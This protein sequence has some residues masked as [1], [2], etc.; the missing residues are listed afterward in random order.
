M[1]TETADLRY[2]FRQAIFTPKGDDP[3]RKRVFVYLPREVI[4]SLQ[5]GDGDCITFAVSPKLPYVVLINLRNN[6]SLPKNLGGDS[7]DPRLMVATLQ[8]E[9]FEL[10]ARR[11]VL[12][13][14][15]NTHAIDNQKYLEE[16]NRIRQR[17]DEIRNGLLKIYS[18]RLYR[19]SELDLDEIESTQILA[20]VRERAEGV[21]SEVASLLS[22]MER[23]S[24]KLEILNTLLDG[25]LI[26][27][28]AH[29]Q[30]R[31]L[32]KLKLQVAEDAL[33]GVS[34]LLKQR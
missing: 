19:G 31:E 32:T 22:D 20:F 12:E 16:K 21:V 23:Y 7:D 1:T 34:K 18:T 5:I 25:G 9:L 17:V 29:K 33:D 4:D 13:E 8:A 27:T 11:D 30:A 15:W 24:R 26:D 14:A 28:S 10:D 2:P 3:K 6:P